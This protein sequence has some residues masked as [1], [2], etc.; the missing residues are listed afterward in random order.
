M[1]SISLRDVIVASLTRRWADLSDD[2]REWALGRGF[3]RVGEVS[4]ECVSAD[5]WDTALHYGD[6]VEG[7]ASCPAYRLA[8]AVDGRPV[9]EVE[10][11]H[12]VGAWDDYQG[13]DDFA[14]HDDD[15]AYS[16]LPHCEGQYLDSGMPNGASGLHLSRV[17]DGVLVVVDDDQA[18]D[19]VRDAAS[20]AD[21]GEA[22]CAESLLELTGRWWGRDSTVYVVREWKVVGVEIETCTRWGVTGYRTSDDRETAYDTEAE[23]LGSIDETTYANED[24]ARASLASEA[25]GEMASAELPT[26]LAWGRDEDGVA[27]KNEGDEE[28]EGYYLDE[29]DLG[30]VCREG[31]WGIYPYIEHLLAPA[32]WHAA[33]ADLA[34]LSHEAP[35]FAIADRLAEAGEEAA[36]KVARAMMKKESANA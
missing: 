29:T 10:G 30:T 25:E 13:H 11:W 34:E 36:E 23:A 2:E 6:D 12:Y 3:A 33:L 18:N 22:P 21:H 15:G 28:I 32:E 27:V 4:A 9:G 7:V 20:D 8:V 24:E 31:W 5:H 19:A 17:V 1:A 14:T 16:G 35:M 26:G